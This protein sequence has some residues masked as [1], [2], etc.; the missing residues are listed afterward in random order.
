MTFWENILL[1]L[2]ERHQPLASDSQRGLSLAP[3]PVQVS[4]ESRGERGVGMKRMQTMEN[5][6]FL[7][8]LLPEQFVTPS[9]GRLKQR[10]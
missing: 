6:S 4:W 10:G 2:G 1:I 3:G 9:R 7:V 5:P 8:P